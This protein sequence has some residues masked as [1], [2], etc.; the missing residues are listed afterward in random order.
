MRRKHFQV[1][2]PLRAISPEKQLGYALR[3]AKVSSRDSDLFII[4][5]ISG[6]DKL[7]TLP[8]EHAPALEIDALKDKLSHT[9]EEIRGKSSKLTV[10]DLRRLLFR[11]AA[12][13]IA[14]ED[15]SYLLKVCHRLALTLAFRRIMIYFYILSLYRSMWRPRPQS[16]QALMCGIG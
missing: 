9:L 3:I 12:T 6:I 16:L 5:S 11:C 1:R 14:M 10:H 2:L 8:P 4:N 15:A 13:I 7:A